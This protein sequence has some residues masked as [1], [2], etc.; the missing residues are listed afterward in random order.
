MLAFRTTPNEIL[1]LH[2]EGRL[3][4]EIANFLRRAGYDVRPA[5]KRSWRESLGELAR[6]LTEAG[7]GGIDALVEYQM[8]RSSR[9]IDVILAGIHPVTGRDAYLVVELKQWSSAVSLDHAAG[10]VSVP[11]LVGPQLHPRLQVQGYCDYLTDHLTALWDWP[12]ALHGV[13]YLHNAPREK[14]SDLVVGKWTYQNLVYTRERRQ[15]FNSYLR[16]RF[17]PRGGTRAADRLLNCAVRPSRQLLAHAAAELGSRRIFVLLDEQRRAYE[18]VA[19]A[20]RESRQGR[21]KRAVIITGG[22]GSGKSAVALSLL[23]DLAGEGRL[24]AHAAGSKAF[25]LSLQ[26][27]ARK[28]PRN[29]RQRTR[30]LFSFF[31]DFMDDERDNLDVL[32]CDEA[33]RI[34]KHSDKGGRTGDIPQVD[35]LL[36][37]AKVPVFLLDDHQVV[38]PGEVGGADMIE[39]AARRQGYDVDLVHLDA[40]FRCGGSAKYDEWLLRL[41]GM[42]DAGPYPWPGDDRFEVGMVSSPEEM[43]AILRARE[44]AGETGRISAG[45]CWPWTRRQNKDGSLPLDVRIGSWAKPWNAAPERPIA[46]VPASSYWATDPAGFDQVGCIYTAQG[47][48]YDW[49]G[50]IIGPD[51]VARGGRLES[52]PRKSRDRA[53]THPER[54]MSREEADQLIRNTYRVLLTRGLRGVLFYSTDDATRQYLADFVPSAMAGFR[55]ESAGVHRAVQPIHAQQRAPVAEVPVHEDV[56]RRGVETGGS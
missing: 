42:T 7:L 39:R 37:A 30:P 52:D 32:V 4:R 21:K 36:S 5:E 15:K 3:D 35:E 45:F 19:Q 44:Q 34:R 25:T 43:E 27:Y 24:V 38:R 28:D 23:A 46:G 31:R 53:L 1:I 48:E 22:P 50:V 41:L 12:D 9:R 17:A 18:L 16:G 47:F 20:V 14:V 51:L 29:P 49:S 13:V 11:G 54:P 8:P 2:Q 40:Q 33:H 26:R 55:P 56:S 10:L 6:H